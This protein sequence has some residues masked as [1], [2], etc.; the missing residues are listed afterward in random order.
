MSHHFGLSAPCRALHL[1]PASPAMVQLLSGYL[2]QLLLGIRCQGRGLSLQ[3]S[4]PS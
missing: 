2:Q 4:S 3:Q 1:K